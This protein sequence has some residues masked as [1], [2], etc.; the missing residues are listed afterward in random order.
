MIRNLRKPEQGGSN[1][2]P[3]EKKDGKMTKTIK[4][5]LERWTEW[6][7]DMFT[8]EDITPI[9]EHLEEE[10]WQKNTEAIKEELDTEETNERNEE[11]NDKEKIKKELDT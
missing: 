7:K 11:N 2:N 3:L 1:F 9:M 5:N 8:T 10:Y 4:E 6:I